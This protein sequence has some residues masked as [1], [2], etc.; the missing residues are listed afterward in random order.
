[1]KK[2]GLDFGTTNSAVAVE[3]NGVG[4]VLEIDTKALD[5][6]VVRSMLYLNRREIV[7]DPKLPPIK[8]KEQIFD[9]G[10]FHYEGEFHP[11]IGE[12]AIQKYMEENT[13][14]GSGLR[15]VIFTGKWFESTDVGMVPCEPG[16]G[17]REYYE[18]IDYG[19][20]RLLQA[21]KTALKSPYYKGT[22]VFGKY[23]SLEELIAIFVEEMKKHSEKLI[24]EKID[25]VVCG[26]PVFFS[27]DPLKDQRTQERLE[28]ALRLA[29]FKKISFEFE[30]VAAAK[31]FLAQNKEE[32]LVFVFDFGGG[33]LDT[34]IVKSGKEFEVLSS[35]G[36]Y[37]GGDLLNADILRNKLWSYFGH[38]SI[39]GD[40]GMLV[41]AHIFEGL[42]SWYSIPNLNNPQMLNQLEKVK[43]HNINK[44]A[45]DRLIYFIKANLGFDLYEAIEKAKKEL[46]FKEESVIEF[47]SGPLDINERI[48]REEFEEIIKERVEE[49]ERV[50][51]RTLERARVKPEDISVVVR[52]GGSSLIPVF[53]NLLVK[54]FG[55]E[56]IKQFE[57]FTSIASGLALN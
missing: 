51:K 35:D 44:E 28:E 20:G 27:D 52:T 43:Y 50:I 48:T 2:F 36:V 37:I 34:A 33:T 5:P 11:L 45:I 57:T 13:N 49:I 54:Y 9:I 22:T 16:R 18:E 15:R 42:N 39:Y 10:D 26:R 38:G 8:I 30:P 7:Y 47:K 46:S 53:E 1:M 4:R 29:G 25:E 14:R 55:K 40:K 24:G 21:L 12:S 23:F 32:Q 31:Q 3:D 19:T 17:V 41:P 6:R 56:K